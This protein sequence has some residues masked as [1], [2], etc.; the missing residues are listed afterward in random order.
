MPEEFIEKAIVSF[1]N[2]LRSY[3]A[4]AGGQVLTAVYVE[5]YHIS[6]FD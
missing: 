1:R 2:R 4:A 6:C 5:P 3:V